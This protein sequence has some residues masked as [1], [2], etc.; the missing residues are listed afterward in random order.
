MQPYP[1]RPCLPRGSVDAVFQT[2]IGQRRAGLIR[3]LCCGICL[4][5]MSDV[6]CTYSAATATHF[7]R[8][9]AG[10]TAGKPVL[11][12]GLSH[13]HQHWILTRSPQ[14]RTLPQ[15]ETCS[16][17][18]FDLFLYKK[19]TIYITFIKSFSIIK[20]NITLLQKFQISATIQDKL[21]IRVHTVSFFHFYFFLFFF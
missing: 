16:N 8:E 15:N 21:P 18:V 12:T 4:W 19:G 6:H 10:R 9:S 14:N 20:Y 2:M 1:S 13:W 5:S 7:C 17:C 11:R 3:A